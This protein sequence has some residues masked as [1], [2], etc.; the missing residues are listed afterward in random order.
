MVSIFSNFCETTYSNGKKA[1]TN[2]INI[3]LRISNVFDL[4][5][6]FTFSKIFLLVDE[7]LKRDD[8]KFFILL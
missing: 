6:N 7:L 4:F 5:V 3:V 2:V 1:Q 8:F